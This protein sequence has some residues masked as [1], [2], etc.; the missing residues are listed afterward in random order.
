MTSRSKKKIKKKPYRWVKMT[1]VF[2]G[3]D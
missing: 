1:S 2:A 3:K